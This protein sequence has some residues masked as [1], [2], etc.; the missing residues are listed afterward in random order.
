MRDAIFPTLDAL[1][2]DL[3]AVHVWRRVV[4]LATHCDR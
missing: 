4:A 3:L 2:R 1:G